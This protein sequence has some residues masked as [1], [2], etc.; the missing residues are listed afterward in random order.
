VAVITKL[1]VLDALD[2]IPVCV[3]YEIDGKR[4]DTM[5]ADVRGLESIKPI[6]KRS[7]LEA[8]HRGIRTF[9]ELPKLA[10]EYSASGTGIRRKDR[11]GP[12]PALTRA[13]HELPGIH[14]A[15]RSL[16]VSQPIPG[17]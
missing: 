6:S 13:D 16:E 17:K 4:I 15:L 10:Q 5:P 1:D 12:P 9:E 2:E 14:E 11:H 7:R 8:V 3:G